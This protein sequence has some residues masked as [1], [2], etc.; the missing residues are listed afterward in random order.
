MSDAQ[1]QTINVEAETALLEGKVE[2]LVTTFYSNERPLAGLA[3]LMDWR[4]HGV[5]SKYF[6]SGVI[7]GKAGECVYFPYT[8]HGTTFHLLFVGA[9][10]SST[11]G[12]RLQIPKESVEA[13]HKNLTT[14]KIG[15]IGVSKKDFGNVTEEYFT[16]HFKGI[17]L[18]IT[19]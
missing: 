17:S 2:A 8:R 13:L 5:V 7:T 3:G 4:F 18:W 11:P 1:I 6:K 12:H 16:K 14:L 19:N 10:P 9:G 15:K